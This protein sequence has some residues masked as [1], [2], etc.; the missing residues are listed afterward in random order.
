[1]I[2]QI[3]LYLPTTIIVICYITYII[4]MLISKNKNIGKE[5][6]SYIIS[7]LLSKDR[8]NIIK[9]RNKISYYDLKRKVIKL[10][11]NDYDATNLW[12]ITNGIKEVGISNNKS[13]FKEIISKILNNFLIFELLGLISILLN[14]ITYTISDAKIGIIAMLIILVIHYLYT[15]MYQEVYLWIEENISKKIKDNILKNLL[16]RINIH[17]IINLSEFIILFRFFIILLNKSI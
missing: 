2:Y 6:C 14:N 11:P 17:K 10:S 7:D 15:V 12:A 4:G 9:G 1:M 13:K 5:E 3:L 8:I 16:F